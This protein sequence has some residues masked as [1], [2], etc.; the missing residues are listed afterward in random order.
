MSE[1]QNN[2][3]YDTWRWS[4]SFYTEA[5]TEAAAT[6]AAAAAATADGEERAPS[7]PRRQRA[8]LPCARAKARCNFESNSARGG[9]FSATAAQPQA[10]NP[11]DASSSTLP[12]QPNSRPNAAGQQEHGGPSQVL[13]SQPPASQQP[14]PPPPPPPSGAAAAP[15]I[16]SSSRVPARPGFGLTWEQAE[17]A[18]SDYRIR[19]TP[20]FPFV[21]LDP[22]AT[23]RDVFLS[24]PFLFR[25]ILLVAARVAVPKQC[26]LKRSVSAYVGQHL[27]VM[28]ERSLDLLQGLLVY[29]AWGNLEFYDDKRI[30]HLIYLAVGYVHNLGL[31]QR[32]LPL[33]RKAALAFNP[34]DAKE[35]MRGVYLTTI[36][37]ESHTLE[38][39]RCLLGCYYLMSLNSV[40]FGRRNT[41]GGDYVDHCIDHLRQ[42]V[43]NQTDST[44]ALITRLQ[45]VA[46]RIAAAFPFP[47]LM[48]TAS[49]TT[50]RDTSSP[51]S[52][53]HNHHVAFTDAV[54]EEMRS[55]RRYLDETFTTVAHKHRH[56]NS[57]WIT[58]NYILI[59]LYAPAMWLPSPPNPSSSTTT[60]T[61]LTTT[62]PSS[63][64][65]AASYRQQCLLSCLQ[66]AKSFFGALLSVGPEGLLHRPFPA[67]AEVFFVT[68][69]ASR[70]LLLRQDVHMPLATTTTTAAAADDNGGGPLSG[71]EWDLDAARQTLDLPVVLQRLVESLEGARALRDRRATAAAAAVTTAA[72]TTTGNGGGGSSSAGS[73]NDSVANIDGDKD[74]PFKLYIIKIRW[75]KGWLET[76]L[77][78]NRSAVTATTA[79]TESSEAAE[80]EHRRDAVEPGGSGSGGGGG[81]GAS[82]HGH[83]GAYDWFG[84]GLGL[85]RYN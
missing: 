83:Q 5:E 70:L 48:T 54:Q 24:R 12:L 15:N 64:A 65:A 40:Q 56:F 21:P 39:R 44:L 13:P 59:R 51:D 4:A 55:I 76:R 49:T 66:A 10:R 81:G 67:F 6:A 19:L 36:A 58:H 43:D 74:D 84:F 30:T 23:A 18:V 42:S 53:S 26:E 77:A 28:E 16:S 20:H 37:E 68:I 27:V 60:S 45:Q 34:G 79:G 17:Q 73:N 78:E 32:P 33:Q 8:C 82:S 35:A 11:R 71:W 80:A 41:L 50:T 2:V 57:L 9:Y 29:I 63:A 22:D 3:S 61:P 69:A 1:S 31:S 62:T 52:H 7:P 14:P 38:E 47:Y 72:T 75:V 85:M 25:V 46:E